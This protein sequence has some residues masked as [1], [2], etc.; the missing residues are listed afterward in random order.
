MDPKGSGA[1]VD[2]VEGM[3]PA[4]APAEGEVMTDDLS[5]GP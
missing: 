5:M 1:T 4:G 3:L 2:T